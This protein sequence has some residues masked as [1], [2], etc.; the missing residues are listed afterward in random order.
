MP[1]PA[2][3][4]EDGSDCKITGL[5]ARAYKIPTESAEA[6]G[7]IDWDSTTLVV[8]TVKAG[9][10]SGTGYTYASLASAVLVDEVLSKA[11]AEQ[12]VFDIPHCWGLMCRSVRNIGRS[13]AAACAISAVDAAL[14]DL[15]AK[16][17]N[18]P[19]AKLLGT[20]R[21]K[22]EVYGSGGFTTFGPEKITSQF[23]NWK[24]Q[25]IK[26]FKI[27]IGRDEKA[28]FE[29]VKAAH[30]ALPPGGRLFVDANGAYQ[31]K[32]ALLMAE[33]LGEYNIAWFEEPVT[34]DDV[35]GLKLLRLQAKTNIAAGE[36]CY[37][38]DDFRHLLEAEAV[39]ILQADAT[40]CLGLTGFLQAAQ[41]ADSYHRQLSSHCA[42][43]LHNAI[44]CHAQT[45]IHM[46]YFSDHARIE[47]LL[48]DGVPPVINGYLTPQAD[49]PGF[50]FT[51]KLKEAE[52]FAI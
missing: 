39:D 51:F 9:G 6:D 42:P 12:D 16:L 52:K 32:Q 29:R 34:S 3:K 33:K 47:K 27:K 19:L 17:L 30:K 18:L 28:D 37:N 50:G 4:S 41:L 35:E 43:A 36:Y 38:A 25:G 31:P 26:K 48:F 7:T 45:G 11:I 15:K 5:T 10:K 13:G 8:A 2:I 44:M 49:R 46:E 20:C 24:E 1:A 14:W 22:I 23:E 21:E 40:R